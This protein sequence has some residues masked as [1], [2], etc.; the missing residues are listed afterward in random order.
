MADSAAALLG[1]T[2]L[3]ERAVGYLRGCL[4]LV[5]PALLDRPTPCADWNLRTLLL[6][7][8]RSM[9]AVQEAADEGA[10]VVRPP[11]GDLDPRFDPVAAVRRSAGSLI[12]AWANEPHPLVSVGGWPVPSGYIAGAGA[13]EIAVHGWDVAAACRHSRRIPAPLA[14]EVLA[15][16]HDLVLPA[17]RPQRFAAPIDAVPWAPADHR[18]LAYLGRRS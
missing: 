12:G 11:V 14:E 5:E 6:H 2:A 13:L 10:V 3:L 8:N 7:L 18:L 15:L 4:R 9:A 17:D 1:E 16:C